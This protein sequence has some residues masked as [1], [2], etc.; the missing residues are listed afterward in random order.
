MGS[1]GP[2]QPQARINEQ[3]Q[4]RQAHNLHHH[5]QAQ[6]GQCRRRRIGPNELRK[7]CNEKEN[8]LGIGERQTKGLPKGGA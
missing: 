3:H 5:A 7:K 6:V 1:K 4:I 8:G 2:L